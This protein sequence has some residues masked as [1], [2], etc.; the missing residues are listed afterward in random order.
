MVMVAAGG[1]GQPDHHSADLAS[2]K[3]RET[4]A[5]ARWDRDL[6]GTRPLPMMGRY[7]AATALATLCLALAIL[8]LRSTSMVWSLAGILGFAALAPTAILIASRRLSMR[9]FR[10]SEQHPLGAVA[11]PPLLFDGHRRRGVIVDGLVGPAPISA[12]GCVAYAVGLHHRAAK[13][14]TLIASEAATRGF[15]IATDDGDVIDILPGGAVLDG[16]FEVVDPDTERLRTYLARLN[17]IGERG[18][19]LIDLDEVRELRLEIGDRVVFFGELL[20]VP[21][22]NGEPS[23]YR[24]PPARRLVP[25][26]TPMLERLTHG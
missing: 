14:S 9:S 4:L 18:Q 1:C 8:V 19:R 10:R 13:P 11:P 16:T 15:K 3:G 25:A 22:P 23:T 2:D 12:N 26:G 20:E 6:D 17:L 21:D 24:E 7:G 5:R